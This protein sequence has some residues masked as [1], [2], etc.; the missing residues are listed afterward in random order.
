VMQI[1]RDKGF[2]VKEE[3]F[4]R[5][6]LYIADEAFFTGTAAEITPIREADKRK[7]GE[8]K[9]GPVTKTIQETFFNIVKGREKKYEGWLTYV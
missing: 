4:T 9:P 8:G 6:E 2:E 3:R 1:A 5:D 7:I